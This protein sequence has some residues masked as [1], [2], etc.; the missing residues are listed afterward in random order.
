MA[1]TEGTSF[2]E[3]WWGKPVDSTV[4]RRSSLMSLATEVHRE[5]LRPDV[6]RLTLS[7]QF[8]EEWRWML[9]AVNDSEACRR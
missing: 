3:R 5:W 9:E 8:G 6:Q 1:E 4:A 2:V 7:D